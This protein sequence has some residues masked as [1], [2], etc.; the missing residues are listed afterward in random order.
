MFTTIWWKLLSLHSVGI[1]DRPANNQQQK[2]RA[3]MQDHKL[4]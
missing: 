4:W 1:T 3:C 2:K